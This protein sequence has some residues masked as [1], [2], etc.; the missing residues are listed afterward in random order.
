MNMINKYLKKDPQKKNKKIKKHQKIMIFLYNT[1]NQSSKFE[2]KYWVEINDESR[3]R[4]LI[5]LT[6]LIKLDL[7]H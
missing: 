2:T 1:P 7:K 3:G 6:K 4:K 5:K